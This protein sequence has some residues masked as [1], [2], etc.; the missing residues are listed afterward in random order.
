MG[1]P[2]PAAGARDSRGY[3]LRPD[4]FRFN[5]VTCAAEDMLRVPKI[6][7]GHQRQSGRKVVLL[8]LRE[9]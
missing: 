2:L 3:S 5:N 4:P 7:P 1:Q 8:P 6:E 9:F